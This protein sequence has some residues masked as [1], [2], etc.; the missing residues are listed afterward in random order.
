MS[1]DF[2]EAHELMSGIHS[3]SVDWSAS[4]A[5][6]TMSTGLKIPIPLDP[7]PADLHGFIR[8]SKY[9]PHSSELRLETDRGDT[10][11]IEIPK[12]HD[13]APRGGRPVI[14]LDQ[15]DWSLLSNAL[16]E[17]RR[18][19]SPVEREAAEYLIN[20]ARQKRV[21]LPM[22]MGHLTETAKWTNA[23]RR[24]PLALTVLELSRGWQ[25]RHPLDIR[26]YELRFSLSNRVKQEQVPNVHAITLEAFAAQPGLFSRS[27]Q[28]ASSG[29]PLGLAIAI[30]AVTSMSSYSSAILDSDAVPMGDISSWVVGNQALT[31]WLAGRQESTSRKRNHVRPYFLRDLS[32]EIA[33]AAQSLG[34]SSEGLK[35]WLE[36]YCFQDLRE[37]PSL[38]LF[39][40]V[41][42]DRHLNRT[43]VWRSNDLTDMMF[44][45]SG[46]A[47]AEY[48][49]GERS[50]VSRI[51]QAARRLRRRINIYP[52]LSE[53][54]ADLQR[55]IS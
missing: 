30:D 31:D 53:L 42:H 20:L 2:E 43:T 47:Y 44:L 15:K 35:M 5:E 3:M 45:C 8:T 24:Y 29:L 14:Y 23:E 4:I 6:I 7:L 51:R 25:V 46:A 26:Q 9:F 22:S 54:V 12:L 48:V 40:E 49:V 32:P 16:Y 39:Q 1:A 19:A 50:Q 17:P 13:P 28:G 21:I 10:L 27:S 33:E 37:M 18:V 36:N 41:Y 11:V 34:V 38:S 55:Q 52:T